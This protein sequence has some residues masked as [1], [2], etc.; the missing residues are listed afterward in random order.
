MAVHIWNRTSVNSTSRLYLIKVYKALINN[1]YE[2]AKAKILA[3]IVLERRVQGNLG[4]SFSLPEHNMLSNSLVDEFNLLRRA[5]VTRPSTI[6]SHLFLEQTY[7]KFIGKLDDVTTLTPKIDKERANIIAQKWNSILLEKDGTTPH[8]SDDDIKKVM[9]CNKTAKVEWYDSLSLSELPVDSFSKM[10]S[11]AIS[12]SKTEKYLHEILQNILTNILMPQ[13]DWIELIN[14]LSLANGFSASVEILAA[15]NNMQVALWHYIFNRNLLVLETADYFSNIIPKL[16]ELLRP[17]IQLLKTA[18]LVFCAK[19]KIYVFCAKDKI[20]VFK[21]PL[22]MQIDENKRLHNATGPAVTFVDNSKVW[23]WHGV[24]VPEYVITEPNRI[25]AKDILEEPNAEVSRIKLERLGMEKFIHQSKLKI[26]YS[27]IDGK[28]N[29]RKLLQTS[30]PKSLESDKYIEVIQVVC[31]STGR[32]YLLRVP[33]NMQTCQAAIAW[34]FGLS[35]ED[36]VLAAE[37]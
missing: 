25:T 29:S 28:G 33:P 5:Q 37:T 12:Y 27:D 36:Y 23:V 7:D 11:L 16:S 3:C 13:K 34:T 31:P 18:L 24:L 21:K 10:S 22:D 20:Y 14:I 35:P 9:G 6:A 8:P 2:P 32:K 15:E 4:R 26:L 19:D 17:V 1:G 30:S